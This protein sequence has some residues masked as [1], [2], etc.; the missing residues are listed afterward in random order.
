MIS[1]AFGEVKGSV[2]LLLAKNHPV[3]S[4]ALS[5]SPGKN[6]FKGGKSSNDF[7]RLG[8]GERECQTLTELKPPRSY[9][10]FSSRSPVRK[11]PV[12]MEDL[13]PTSGNPQPV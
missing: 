1:P 8:R 9:S 4:P 6:P 12:E 7:P 2:R 3:P 11:F 5:R 13:L 10:C